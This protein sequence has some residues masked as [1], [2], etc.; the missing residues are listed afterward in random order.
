VLL[1]SYPLPETLPLPASAQSFFLRV[2]D[3]A[4]YAPNVDT[5]KPI[6]CMLNGAC[7]GLLTLLSSEARHSFD[8]ELCQI[9]SSH[10]TGQNSMLLLWCFGIVILAEHPQGT[11]DLHSTS[12]AFS[13]TSLATGDRQWTTASGR[14]LFGSTAGINKT[15][16]LTYLSVIW[17][18]KGDVGVS[19]TE[20][21][22][23]IR[24][25]TRTVRCV[26]Q[27]T[28]QN[29]PNSSRIAQS[30]FPKLPT[31]ILRHDINPALQLEVYSIQVP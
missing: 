25:A 7:R 28:R 5:L 9:L 2:F 15:I 17:A 12:S 30:T 29:W 27:T 6:Y 21:I 31:K 14:K 10:G 26:D 8:K 18:S 23:A 11:E 13:T 3:K 4:T 20:A 1:L 24:I 22:E 19:D 16:N